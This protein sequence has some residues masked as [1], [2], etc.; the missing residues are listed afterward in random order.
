MKRG[1]L[2]IPRTLALEI[3]R[4]AIHTGDLSAVCT[5]IAYQLGSAVFGRLRTPLINYFQTWCGN[6]L[7][8]GF[9]PRW[10]Q[11]NYPFTKN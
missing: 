5:D 9:N 7:E 6:R 2:T 4:I 1:R 11:N 3:E 10:E 8:K